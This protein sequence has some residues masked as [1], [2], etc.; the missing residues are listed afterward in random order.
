MY[1]EK[2]QLDEFS[3][4]NNFDYNNLSTWEDYYE[5]SRQYY[6]WT[7]NKTPDVMWDG[8]SFMG[9]DSIPNYV[10]V[11]NKQL[12][13]DIIDSTNKNVVLNRDA[14][15]RVFDIYYKGTSMGYFN[16]V[17]AFRSDDVKA[18]ELIGYAG[19]TSGVAFFPTSIVSGEDILPSELL[20]KNYPV[21]EGGESY[22][23]QQG[24]NMAIAVSTPA[25]QEGASLF[26]KWIT[27]P[28]QNL[29]FAMSSGYLPVEKDAFGDNFDAKIDEMTKGDQSQQNIANAY[30][31][32]SDQILN[33]NTYA[34]EVFE[35]S[36]SVRS[37]LSDTLNSIV[38]EG[39]DSV[40]TLKS[41]VT[42]E[43]ELIKKLEVDA[44]FENWISNIEIEFTKSNINY[45]I[46]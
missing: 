22:A 7:D 3:K 44:Q 8:K 34:T 41:T 18:N 33:R 30:G 46:N 36:Y 5:L 4:E 39:K 37:I 10:I 45:V 40:T 24:A 29:A 28:E 26:L 13:V 27:E 31:F 15:K 19:S 6:I 2:N 9:F 38:D 1:L 20:I 16:A 21:F 14:L 42:T 12:G 11:G 43:D 17:G 32:S 35:G 23:I 25:K